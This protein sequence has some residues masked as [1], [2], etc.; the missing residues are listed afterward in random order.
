MA[1][2]AKNEQ[3]SETVTEISL[4]TS[5]IECLCA[6]SHEY[7]YSIVCRPPDGN[8]VS[9]IDHLDTLQSYVNDNRYKIILGG[10]INIDLPH[11]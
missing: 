2:L 10:D 11:F 1:I 5:N 4:I 7:V 9:F 3:N 6:L 8:T